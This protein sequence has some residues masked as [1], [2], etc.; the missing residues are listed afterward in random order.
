M[1]T[2]FP[3]HPIPSLWC[4]CY[5]DSLRSPIRCENQKLRFKL[6][7]SFFF[8]LLLH[9]NLVDC[10][11]CWKEQHIFLSHP[12]LHSLVLY[13]SLLPSPLNSINCSVAN[14]ICQGLICSVTLPQLPTILLPCVNCASVVLLSK[15]IVFFVFFVIVALGGCRQQNY[16]HRSYKILSIQITGQLSSDEWVGELF[17]PPLGSLRIKLLKVPRLG[18]L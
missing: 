7:V 5:S 12:S 16:I 1:L 6:S 2:C 18:S 13:L 15:F 17:F 14:I 10:R 11:S 4:P 9:P 8:C 3:H